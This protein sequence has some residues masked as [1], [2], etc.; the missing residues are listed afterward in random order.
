MSADTE[1]A[2]VTRSLRR[3]DHDPT[4]TIRP[5]PIDLTPRAE[6]VSDTPDMRTLPPLSLGPAPDLP[7]GVTLPRRTNS[8][9][10]DLAVTAVLGEG[11]T[12][13][14]LLAYQSSMGREV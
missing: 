11:G 14:V 10:P 13:T 5:Q 3:A 2:A 9:A 12:G 4:A 7:A 6:L 8:E 1:L